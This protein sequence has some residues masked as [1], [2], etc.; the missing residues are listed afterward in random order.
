MKLL[1]WLLEHPSSGFCGLSWG[2]PYPWQDIGF[3]APKWLP[4]RVVT[5][6][7]GFAMVKAAEITGEDRYREALPRL[8]EFLTG[9]PNVL[10]DSED[11]KCYSYLPDASVTWA[12]M[13][14]PAL[15][16]AFLAEAGQLLERTEYISEARRL[17]N[18]VA[19]KQTDYGAWYYTYPPGD[20][21]ITHDNYHTAIILDCL[22]R[23]REA[24]GD[25]SFIQVYR[26]GLD[27]YRRELFNED[28]SPRWMNN[29]DY[30]HDI[31]GAASGILCFVR[32]VQHNPAYLTQADQ[33]LS[34]TLGHMLDSRGY[35]YYQETPLFRRSFTLMRWCNAWMAWAMATWLRN[36]S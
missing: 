1:D 19:D 24:S 11:M 27:Y 22:D 31:H 36:R 35:F 5:C 34:W 25:E 33:I 14:V 4:N 6:W 8:A 20:S 23:Y 3:Y 7:I 32:A 29:R 2:Y 9:E 18:W 21:H 30:P 17:I 12:V 15:V 28:G 10:H 16:G 26:L 13:D